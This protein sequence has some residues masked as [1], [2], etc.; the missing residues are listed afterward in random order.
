M[1]TRV[2]ILPLV[3]FSTVASAQT[4]YSGLSLDLSGV[5]AQQLAIGATL[6]GALGVVVGFRYIK[7]MIS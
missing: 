6:L 1:F 2:A 3:F 4:D 5:E 7:R